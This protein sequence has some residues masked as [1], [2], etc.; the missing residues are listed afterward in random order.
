MSSLNPLIKVRAIT[1][2]IV[3]TT[4]STTWAGSLFKA[5]DLALDLL[6]R[7]NDM[8]YEVQTLRIVTNP[9]GEWLNVETSATAISG[10][11]TFKLSL[12][13]ATSKSL[14]PLPRIRV[15]IGAAT[16]SHDLSLVPALIMAHGDLANV[17][18]NVGFDEASGLIDQS[19]C[20]QAAAVMLQLSKCTPRGEG[21][22]NFTA[23]FHCPPLIPYFPAGYNTAANGPSFAIGLEHPDL[24][25]SLLEPLHLGSVPS[26]SRPAAFSSALSLLTAGVESHVSLLA[27]AA[28][29]VAQER[30]VAFSGL[31]SS[32]APSKDVSS[33]CRLFE[34]LGVPHFGASGSVEAAAFLT[35]VFKAIKG[36]PLIGFSGL[37]LTC[38]EDTGMAKSATR[39]EYDIRALLQYSCVCGIGLDCIPV[40]EMM[41][42]S[43][44]T[45]NLCLEFCL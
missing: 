15:A 33:M 12:A 30:G 8:G 18:L 9:F 21:N 25:C 2:F 17:C 43:T 27:G 11:E 45:T 4:D 28:A 40:S 38:L 44:S 22:F 5:T 20:D 14:T 13:E 36:V 37:M 42:R 41:R 26:V 6:T 29:A 34:L 19:L 23:N 39:G 7:Y 10:L 32:A 35:K 16:T 31:D 3:L 1:S 24:L